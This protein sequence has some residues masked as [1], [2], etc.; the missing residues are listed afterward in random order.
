[1]VD[2]NTSHG[3]TVKKLLI[4]ETIIWLTTLAAT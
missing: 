1:M 4:S 2:F 3:R